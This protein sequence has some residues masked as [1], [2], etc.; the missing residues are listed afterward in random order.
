MGLKFDKIGYWS[1]VKLDVIREYATKYSTI[2]AAQPSLSHVYI[3]G[4]SGA[5]KHVRK[6]TGEFVVGSPLNALMVD[7]PFDNYYLIDLDGHKVEHL[8]ESVGPREDV[9][10]YHG[11][12]NKVLL[13]DVFPHVQYGDYRRGLCILDPYGLHLDWRVLEAAGKME[14]LDIFLN[15][16]IMDMNRN[17]LWRNPDGADEADVARMTAFWGDD[18]WRGVTYKKKPQYNLFGE[19]REEEKVAGN[20]AVVEAF[21]KRLVETAGFKKVPPPMPMR[22]SIGAVVYYL[23]FASAKPV[24]M[25]IVEHIF[26]KY[27]GRG[28]G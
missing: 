18:S 24:A 9:R 1:E 28:R 15:F 10:I 26:E 12:C 8:R 14:T 5:G 27:Q 19:N 25:K 17:A 22:N 6:Q 23:F 16:P 7:P 2:L 4:F 20:E 13:Q 11:D 3:D 21:R